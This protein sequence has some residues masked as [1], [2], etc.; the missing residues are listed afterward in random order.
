MQN[1]QIYYSEKEILPIS[2][3]TKNMTTKF[4]N[5][6]PNVKLRQATGTP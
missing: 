3:L 4:L 5:N 6:F 2:N 1:K